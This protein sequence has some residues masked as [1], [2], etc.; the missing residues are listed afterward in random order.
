MIFITSQLETYSWF[1]HIKKIL[2]TV[3]GSFRDTMVS[4]SISFSWSCSQVVSCPQ[5]VCVEG[6]K[7]DIKDGPSYTC[8]FFIREPKAFLEA[9]I[10]FCFPLLALFPSTPV[11]KWNW[12]INSYTFQTLYWS[13]GQEKK[14]ANGCCVRQLRMT[15]TDPCC[16]YENPTKLV[17]LFITVL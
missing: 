6:K 16:P 7:K 17:L 8:L 13:R 15:A 14:I 1:F 11:C 5:H 12:K 3:I 9:P 2:E 4:D 10:D